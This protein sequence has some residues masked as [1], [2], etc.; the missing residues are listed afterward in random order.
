MRIQKFL[1]IFLVLISSLVKAIEDKT[2][3]ILH[4]YNQGLSWTD[5]L[6]NSIVEQLSQSEHITIDIRIEYM[7]T[8]RFEHESYL[9]S[10]AE[11]LLPKYK[12]TQ[13][14]LIISTD[15][16]AFEFLKKYQE[17]F[18]KNTPVVFCGLNNVSTYPEGFTGIIE[19]IDVEDNLKSILSIHPDYRKIYI[20]IDNSITGKAIKQQAS[21][22]INAKF[23]NLKYEYLTDYSF[24][25]LKTKLSTLSNGDIFLL[26]IFNYDKEGEIIPYDIIL[27]EITPFCKVPIYGTW[28]FYLEKGIIGGKI[29][30]GYYHG[31]EAGSI[32]TQ[33]LQGLNINDIPVSS[34]PTKYIFDFPQLEAHNISTDALPQGS[35]IVNKPTNVF[36]KNKELFALIASIILLLTVTIIFLLIIVRKEQKALVKERLFLNEIESKKV[37]LQRALSEANQA[38]QLQRSFLANLSHEIRTPMNGILGFSGLLSEL[39]TQDPEAINYINHINSN[40][41][42]LLNIIDDIL[43]VSRIETQQT[44][45]FISTVN[46]HRLID[47]VVENF[48]QK[49]SGLEDI[50]LHTNYALQTDQTN[51]KTDETKLKQVFNN[52]L[53]NA[54]K[55]TSQGSINLSYV[56]RDGMIEFAVK[57]TGIGIKPENHDLIFTRFGQVEKGLSR[58]YGGTGLGLTITKAF[59]ELMGGEIWLQ[60]TYGKG[61]TFYFTHPADFIDKK[62]QQESRVSTSNY[63]WNKKSVLIAEDEKLNYTYLVAALKATKINVLHATNG[64]EAIDLCKA[65]PEIDM[66]LMDIKMPDMDGFEATRQI[67]KYFPN[68][69]VIAQTA[70]STNYDYNKAHESGIDDKIFKPI[71]K[72]ELLHLMSH[73]LEEMPNEN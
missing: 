57:D 24:D 38:N 66:V 3:L 13:L 18:V 62:T 19:N 58:Q 34:G 55:F 52:L 31:L 67:K 53:D 60:S 56:L 45:K 30:S 46:L 51:L 42:L 43:E 70:Y 29:T 15:N 54:L 12:D 23:P 41:K 25:E 16:A 44:E 63:N 20:A 5:N 17:S 1:I 22:V 11:Y 47:E 59:V 28:D 40:G 33:I 36:T 73:Y 4:S 37:A 8:K 2:V 14:D 9:Q 72:K 68:I 49:S 6:N 69:P 32:A 48:R 7:D 39:T 71:N 50:T 64:R 21:S 35:I 26:I 10:Y 61:S 27:E 65:Y